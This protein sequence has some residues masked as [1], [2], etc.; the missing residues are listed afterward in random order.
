KRRQLAPHLAELNEA[1]DRS[2]QMICW[3]MTFE[4]ELVEQGFLPA[5]TFPHHRFAPQSPTDQSES[6][7]PNPRNTYFSNRIRRNRPSAGLPGTRLFATL[8]CD[9][10]RDGPHL[11]ASG[12][13]ALYGKRNRG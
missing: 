9:R 4:R 3:H 2:Q 6:A 1:V 11:V 13:I 8:K 7:D 12:C 10:Q 5:P